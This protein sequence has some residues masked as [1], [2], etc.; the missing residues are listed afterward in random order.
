MWLHRAEY[1]I[2]PKDEG[3]LFLSNGKVGYQEP[4]FKLASTVVGMEVMVRNMKAM[5][6][7]GLSDV[8]RMASLTPAER[9]G[10]AGDIGSLEIGKLADVLVLDKSMNVQRVFVGGLERTSRSA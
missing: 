7:A 4:G 10:M 5:T 1:R 9:V 3:E 8:V 2:G 6:S